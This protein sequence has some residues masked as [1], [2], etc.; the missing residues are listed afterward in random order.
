MD[1]ATRYTLVFLAT[2]YHPP[3]LEIRSIPDTYESITQT[4][5]CT[6]R[7][8]HGDELGESNAF[9]DLV[10]ECGYTYEHI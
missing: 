7:T 10:K 5:H 1:R 6:V 3:I 8:D 2:T 4:L 9:K